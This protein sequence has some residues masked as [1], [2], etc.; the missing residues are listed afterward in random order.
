MFPGREC[1]LGLHSK[2]STVERSHTNSLSNCYSEPLQYC[3]SRMA[4][5]ESGIEI[6]EALKFSVDFTQIVKT[7]WS[8]PTSTHSIWNIIK[9]Y[10]RAFYKSIC[11]L[12]FLLHA[13]V[14]K[15]VIAILGNIENVA[16]TLLKIGENNIDLYMYITLS[17]IHFTGPY[18]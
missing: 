2:H 12:F 7:H 6:S 11:D 17:R 1:N 5:D 9:Q 14:G 18:I 16:V 4:Y 10:T 15:V 13:D 8:F 3:L